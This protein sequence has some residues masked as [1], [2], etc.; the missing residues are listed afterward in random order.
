M[1]HQEPLSPDRIPLEDWQNTP[2]SVK[3]LVELLLTRSVLTQEANSAFKP[4]P[5]QNEGRSHF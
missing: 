1:T 2:E 4:D 5:T 3:R